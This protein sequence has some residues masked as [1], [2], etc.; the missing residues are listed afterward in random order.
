MM[1]RE[2]GNY[3]MPASPTCSKH[4]SQRITI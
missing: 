3:L 4:L 2:T 1:H